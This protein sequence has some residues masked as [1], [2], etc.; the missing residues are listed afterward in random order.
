MIA[1]FDIGGSTIKAAAVHGPNDIAIL[2]KRETPLQ[3]FDE[4]VDVIKAQ[5]EDIHLGSSSTPHHKGIAISL[6]G[7]IDSQT[8]L[9]KCA[10]IPCLDQRPLRTDLA[11]ALA[12]PVQLANDAD[13]FALAEA[14]FGAG[15]GHH[16]VFG[17]VLGSGVGG[18]LVLDGKL[19]E[20]AGGFAGEWGHG[21]ALANISEHWPDPI[22]HF[23]CGCGQKGCLDTI[24]GARGLERLHQHLHGENL[25]STQIVENWLLNHPQ[26]G[27]SVDIMIDLISG[28]LAMVLNITGSSI[29]P[30][31]GG[32]SGTHQLIKKLD[33]AVRAKILRKSQ[34]PVVV[35]HQCNP[36]P[37]LLGAAMLVMQK[38]G[39]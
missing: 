39:T 4:F 15:Q 33:K 1:T 3:D 13:C 7:I 19:V 29:S 2:P 16:N 9:A 6:A 28:P 8:G 25:P 17:I 12:V 18:G 34:N 14:H 20:G 38:F 36:E 21:P 32:L 31:G 30:V 27:Q 24:G 26:A 37:G 23:N 5:I 22:P 11:Q 35:T 10:N